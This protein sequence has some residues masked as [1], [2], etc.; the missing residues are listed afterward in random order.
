MRDDGRPDP[1]L[2]TAAVGLACAL[3]ACGGGAS[4]PAGPALQ[5]TTETVKLRRGDPLPATSAIFDG[6]TVRLRA[7]RGE[8]VGVAVWRRGAGAAAVRLEVEGARVE[9][10]AVAHHQVRRGSTR[11]YGPVD[12]RGAW[13][14]RLEPVAAGAA[15]DAER[16]AYFDVAV[17]AD[18]APGVH[19][20]ALT[21]DD[22]A[23][24]VELTV[25]P[26]T[27]PSVG[28]APRVWGYYDARE[29][30]RAHELTPGSEAVLAVERDYAAL[31]RAHGMVVTPELTLDSWEV[32]RELVRGLPWIP[33]LLPRD[34]EARDAAVRAWIDRLAGTGQVAFA[35]PIDEPRRLRQKLEVRALAAEVRAAG[36]GAGRFL[37]AV[38]DEPHF[39]YGDLID[40]Y[41]SPYAVHRGAPREVGGAPVERWTYNGGEPFAGPFVLDSGGP[42]LRT[43]GW[44]GWRWDVGLWYVWDVMYWSDR[45]RHR[46]RGGQGLPP[47]SPVDADAVTFDDGDDHGNLDGVL[48]HPGPRASWRLKTLRRGQQDRLLLEALAACAGAAAAEAI[49]A[50]VVPRALGDAGAPGTWRRGDWPRDEAAWEAARGRVLDAWVA[51]EAA[52]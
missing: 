24:A 29:V 7:A 44:I 14:D 35:I 5:I 32:R 22:R 45:Y 37:Y 36:G 23:I 15:V 38:T 46:R 26:V 6:E 11:M 27:L 12:G 17:P 16:V 21:V 19:R 25:A 50:E 30:A 28:D 18:A 39:V 4:A 20:G 48:L 52:R 43:W 49:A 8:V 31:A 9:A 33:V 10:F 3:A 40:V 41:W 13:P 2:T 51:C 47:P 1:A 34:P 42:A